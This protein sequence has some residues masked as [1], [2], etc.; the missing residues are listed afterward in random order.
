MCLPTVFL[1]LFV[2]NVINGGVALEVLIRH[3]EGTY[4]IVQTGFCRPAG[5]VA[6]GLPELHESES[7]IQRQHTDAELVEFFIA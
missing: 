3:D 6:G 7:P 4:E 5:D 1:L 2:K